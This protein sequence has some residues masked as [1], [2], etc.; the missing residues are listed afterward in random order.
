MRVADIYLAGRFTEPAVPAGQA[1]AA[2]PAPAPITLSPEGLEAC[3]GTYWLE[4]NLLRKLVVDKDKLFYVRSA[5]NRSELAPLSPT[6]FRMLGVPGDVLL[7][8]T[9]KSGALFNAFTFT[10]ADGSKIGAKRVEP[11]EPAEAQLKEYAGSYY[12]DELDTRYD[13]ELRSGSL[14]FGA[15]HNEEVRAVPQKKDFF[16]A[17]SGQIEF[18]RDKKGRVTG[19]RIS[20][21]RVLNLKFVRVKAGA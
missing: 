6:R 20:T 2:K 8:F 7:D 19:F 17:E 11:F 5:D 1:P 18:E 4:S 9:D 13:L 15:G 14:W 16:S 10:E 21:G 3:A 12:S